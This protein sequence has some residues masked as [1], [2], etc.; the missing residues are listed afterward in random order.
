MLTKVIWIIPIGCWM[1]YY[2]DY[3]GYKCQRTDET[4][5]SI[6]L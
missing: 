2:D 5:R 6:V 4:N 3:I 1:I